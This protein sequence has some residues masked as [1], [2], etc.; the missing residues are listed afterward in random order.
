MSAPA[1]SLTVD[2]VQLEVIRHALI[3]AAEEMK[4]HLSRT[5]HN[6]IIYEVLDF[7]CGIFD[8]DCRMIAPADGLPS[9]FGNLGVAV[10]TVAADIG[11]ENLSHGDIYL[12][13]APYAQGMHMNDVTTVQ[14]VF[15]DSQHVGFT[16][17]RAHW[18]DI[19]AVDAGRSITSTD[20]VREG[21]WL[22]SVRLYRAGNLDDAVLRAIRFN[23]RMPES[24][25]GDLKA[26]VSASRTDA[27]RVEEIFRRHGAG[28]VSAAVAL[29][30]D[31]SEQRVRA[32][33]RA[34]RNGVY[35]AETALDDDCLGNGPL[36]VGVIGF[37][38]SGT[39]PRTGSTYIHQ[40]PEYG[41][42]GATRDR[43]GESAM[44]FM[45]NAG[46][47]V[48]STET[49]ETRFPLRVTRFSLRPDSG[50]TGRWRG[51]LGTIRDY[52]VLDH[53]ARVMVVTDRHTCPPWGI[54]GGHD[55]AHCV[56]I[57]SDGGDC[58]SRLAKSAGAA[59]R[60][61]NAP[62]AFAPAGEAAAGIR[63]RATLLSSEGMSSPAM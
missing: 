46:C 41:G 19:G 53:D 49:L 13:N 45:T 29:I 37:T 52:E 34:I 4:A 63:S 42:W 48:L 59:R 11:L 57:V 15:V 62:S 25:L 39:H 2:V 27:C 14:P 58:S 23:V 47:R 18:I 33:I 21:I 43:D 35:Q 6:P 22:R 61:A 12:L 26:Q 56:A 55:A 16:A 20:V 17:T 1:A 9:F 38:I 7:S 3:A 60:A 32:A 44:I 50:G 5:A 8:A 36:P 51:G 10:Q 31:Q 40:E 30:V 28:A 24:M 54:D